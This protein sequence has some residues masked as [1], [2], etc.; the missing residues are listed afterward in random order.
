MKA[1]PQTAAGEDIRPV[2]IDL[3]DEPSHTVSAG[4]AY[5][6][7][8]GPSGLFRWQRRNAFHQAETIDVRL[9]AGTIERL[10]EA[11]IRFPHVLRFDRQVTGRLAFRDEETD[12]FDRRAGE[13]SAGFSQ[14]LFGPWETS[15][16]VLAEIS[17]SETQSFDGVVYSLGLPLELIRD[18]RDAP[19]E[20]ADG[21]YAGLRVEPSRVFGDVT[22]N[23]VTLSSDLR[24]Y[25]GVHERLVLAGRMKTSVIVGAEA[26]RLPPESRLFAGGGGSVRG[27]DFQALSPRDED[28]ALIGGA[29]RLELSA[30]AR[31][32]LYGNIGGVVFVDAGG[33]F[34]PKTPQLSEIEWAA[35]LG[36][37]YRTDFGI[38]RADIAFP[39]TTRDRHNTVEFYLSIGQAF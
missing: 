16:R 39:V 10:A 31:M 35:G 9:N 33:A 21:T 12:A 19:L 36:A 26:E 29:S 32:R 4:A 25:F 34:E 30:E 17:S 38:F 3:D 14:P 6:T 15:A 2:R 8:E 24:G 13:I 1:F 22:T 23:F 37:R 7:T 18:A 20:P 27:F 5:S 11:S 28:G